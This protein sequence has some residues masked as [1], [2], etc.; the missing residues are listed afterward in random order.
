MAKI[1]WDGIKEYQAAIAKLEIKT[2]GIMKQA[3]YEGAA[4]VI[5]AVKAECPEDSGDLRASIGLAHMQND[6]GFVHTKLG[7]DGYDGNG[8]PNIVKARV[9]NSGAHGVAKNPFVRRATNKAKEKSKSAMAKEFAK[10]IEK[11]MK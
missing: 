7:F 6:R 5:D 1:E 3:V 8:V 9:I 2:E 10:A 4:V 11:T